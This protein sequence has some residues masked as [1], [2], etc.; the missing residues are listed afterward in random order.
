MNPRARC[1]CCL[2][3]SSQAGPTEVHFMPGPTEVDCQGPQRFILCQGPQRLIARAHRGSFM[4]G[5]TQVHLCQG[6]QRFILCQGSQRFIYA[7][8]HRSSFYVR[9][10]RGSFMSGLTE[11]HFMPEWCIIF[12]SGT[13][14]VQTPPPELPFLRFNFLLFFLLL[15]KL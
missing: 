6:P 8:A 2:Y 14:S 13:L 3:R 7:R 12:E 4:P 10:H 5:P 1:N 9:A 15:N 11:V